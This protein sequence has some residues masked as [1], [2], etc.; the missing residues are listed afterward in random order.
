MSV[1]SSPLISRLENK[2][3]LREV[4]AR[5]KHSPQNFCGH[6][7]TGRLGSDLHVTGQQTNIFKSILELSKFLIGQS[8][9][10]RSI[11]SPERENNPNCDIISYVQNKSAC[12]ETTAVDITGF[13][14]E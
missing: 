4:R 9:D 11:H 8:F 14:K 12:D 1:K 7:K 5:A 13:L 3:E 2:Q 10:R 6:N